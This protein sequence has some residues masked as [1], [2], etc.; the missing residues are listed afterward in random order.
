MTVAGAVAAVS[1]SQLHSSAMFNELVTI[2]GLAAEP[3]GW[4]PIG[5]GGD[6]V[7]GAIVNWPGATLPGL[8]YPRLTT[9]GVLAQSGHPCRAPVHRSSGRPHS[10]KSYP[11]GARLPLI[12]M[13]QHALGLRRSVPPVDRPGRG[14]TPVL[15]LAPPLP[16]EGTSYPSAPVNIMAP[17]MPQG[18]LRGDRQANDVPNHQ[19]AQEDKQSD[20]FDRHQ[21]FTPFSF[22]PQKQSDAERMVSLHG[23]TEF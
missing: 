13:A 18:R 9:L 23:G 17:A 14:V 21:S 6:A 4:A 12:P 16:F 10:L 11:M 7:I 5:H 3:S 15:V 19:L 1:T 22:A 20:A 2:R 8:A